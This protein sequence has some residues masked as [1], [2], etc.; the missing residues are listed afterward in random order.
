M[1]VLVVTE[2]GVDGVFRF[3]EM[4]CHFLIEQGV[5]VHLAYSDCRGSDRLPKLVDLVEE[6]GGTTVNLRTSNRP[7]FS[8]WGA[9]CSLLK[10]ARKVKP[11]V[12]H[13]HSSKAGFLARTLKFFGIRAVQFY[14]PHAY[15]GMRPVPGR[16]DW[17]YNLIESGLGRTA[18]TITVSAD[19]KAYACNCLK[20]PTKR[21]LL[22]KNGVDTDLFTPA[23]PREK[24]RLRAALGLPLHQPILG[25]IGRSS[26][27]KDPL[28][29]Y[30]AFA[31][32][33]AEKPISLF[34]VGQGEL[35]AQLDSLVG[36]LS[37]GQRVFRRP[38]MS[39]PADFYRVVDGFILT[40]RYEGFSLAVL[41]AVSADLP[42][43]LSKAPGNIDLVAQPLSHLWKARPGDVE[44]FSR[45]IA[46]WHER[47]QSPAPINHRQ[48]AQLQFDYR[49]RLG[50]ILG[51][52][53]EMSGAPKPGSYDK[54]AGQ[55]DRK[56]PATSY[57]IK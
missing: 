5:S 49:K 42:M 8:D 26:A 50:D 27:Q 24:L 33:A 56:Q 9:F 10:L 21:V 36:R 1:K 38:Y 30:Q 15:V 43:I 53:Q 18:Y 54:T 55:H 52:Y 46:S 19:E 25:F 37:L 39:A 41:E 57:S 16:F 48:I 34:H 13:S 3:V 22:L 51:K 12:I 29:L 20:I 31:K 45:C 23:S 35:D 32:V 14:H 28:T 17:A 6:H 44:G 40:S 4:L 11:D 47:L 7:A 2:P